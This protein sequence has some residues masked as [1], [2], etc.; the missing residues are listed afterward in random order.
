MSDSTTPQAGTDTSQADTINHQVADTQSSQAPEPEKFDADYVKKLRAEAA[1]YRRK[2][3]DAETKAK[4]ADDAKAAAD[5]AAAAEQGKFKE[6]YESEQK[7]RAELEAKTRQLELAA[8][9]AKVAAATNLPAALA[10]RL[11]GDTEEALTADAKVLL[12]ALPAP[13]AGDNDARRGTGGGTGA[14][15]LTDAQKADFAARYNVD[16]RFVTQDAFMVPG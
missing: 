3:R 9:R 4:E 16:A 14:P 8:L 7:K 6:L 12:A 2:L 11:Q 13:A 5:A 10:S 15:Q 1:D